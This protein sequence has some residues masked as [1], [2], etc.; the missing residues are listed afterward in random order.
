MQK[1]IEQIMKETQ[2]KLPRELKI[3]S[4]DCD[5]KMFGNISGAA[6]GPDFSL[7][8]GTDRGLIEGFITWNTGKEMTIEEC[9]KLFQWKQDPERAKYVDGYS[10]EEFAECLN[11]NLDK[12]RNI[13]RF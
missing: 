6:E 2:D 1:T 5:Y 7:T 3:T 9:L 4:F 13:G 12:I 10:F 8:F 11:E